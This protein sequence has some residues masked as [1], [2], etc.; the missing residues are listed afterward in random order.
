MYESLTIRM[1]FYIIVRQFA[2]ELAK[3]ERRKHTKKYKQFDYAQS[4]C[5]EKQ[6]MI[7]MLF[8][9]L[10]AAAFFF[11]YYFVK[12]ACVAAGL[13]ENGFAAYGIAAVCAV[14]FS[15]ISSRLGVFAVFSIHIMAVSL[16]LWLIYIGASAVYRKATTGKFGKAETK[17]EIKR[18]FMPSTFGIENTAAALTANISA[19]NENAVWTRLYDSRLVPVALTLAI[20]IGGHANMMNVTR[21]DRTIYTEKNIRA[22][23]YKVALIADMHYGVSVGDKTLYRIC[24]EISEAGVDMVVLCGDIVDENTTKEGMHTV[25]DALGGIRSTYGVFYVYGNHDRQTYTA[26]K[27]FTE[28]ELAETIENNG[29][30][31]LC[32]SA[33]KLNDELTVV[34]R[35][36][37]SYR[38]EEGR[39]PVSQLLSG[40]DKTD[41]IITLDHQPRQ[42]KENAL[43]GTNLLLSGHT[44]GGQFWPLNVLF[45]ITD[46]NEA[47]YGYTKIADDAQAFVTSGFAGWGFPIKT[48][49]PAE[50]VVIDIVP[51][52]NK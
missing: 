22:E 46:I 7:Y 2:V 34:G 26:D 32:D 41:Y 29:I 16:G 15:Y 11:Y 20:I 48:V 10:A 52:N 35:Q 3:F 13:D 33:V 17:N 50:Y 30:T 49:C 5:G 8:P 31:L 14:G 39:T 51:V 18:S 1:T 25:F 40:V 36:D 4:K 24:D 47:N 9:L 6:K 27:A 45:E 28:A 12:R 38:G 19:K 21:T 43:A 44:H 23:G 42:Y 37:M